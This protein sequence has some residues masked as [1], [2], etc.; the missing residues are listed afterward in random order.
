MIRV[1]VLK[2]NIVTNQGD[3]ATSQ[4]ATEW[5]DSEKKNKS[6]GRNDRSYIVLDASKLPPGEDPALASRITV[7]PPNLEGIVYTQYD[8]LADYTVQITDVTADHDAIKA[9]QDA[10]KLAFE[11]LKS[12]KPVMTLPEL[13]V[14][15]NK[16][17]QVL[18]IK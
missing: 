16:I 5:L 1:Q 11:E 14:A 8:F 12:T 10:M 17:L 2:N 9:K 15:V 4:L 6:F 3:F 13:S 18:G 7:L